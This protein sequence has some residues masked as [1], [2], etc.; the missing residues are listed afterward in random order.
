MG[1]STV[2]ARLVAVCAVTAVAGGVLAGVPVSAQA[3]GAPSSS[4]ATPNRSVALRAPVGGDGVTPRAARA[5][6]LRIK[7]VGV[8]AG[9][10]ASVK[11][12]GPKQSKR[13]KAKKYSKVIHQTAKLR[14]RPGVYRVISRSVAAIGGTDVPR[15]VTKKLR[16]RNN[17]FTGFTVHYRFVASTPV[18]CGSSAVGDTGPGGGTVFYKDMTRTAGSQCF[19]FA[20]TGWNTA[21]APNDPVLAWGLA[22]CTSWSISTLTTFGSGSANTAAITGACAAAAAPAAWATKNYTS[23][24]GKSDWFLPSQEELDAQCQWARNI[25]NPVAMANPGACSTGSGTLRGGFAPGYYWS[26]S[27][28]LADNAWALIFHFGVPGPPGKTNA[29]SVRPVRAF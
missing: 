9:G 19:E 7:I 20:P 12:T 8:T 2:L 21:T 15:V 25:N 3:P 4:V 14:V 5:T 23:P 28:D 11:V 29:L 13:K 10:R 22:A 27:Q 1:K 18:T 24:T 17:R 26:S 6:G 16:V